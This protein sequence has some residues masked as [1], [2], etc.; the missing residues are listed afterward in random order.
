[1]THLPF[2]NKLLNQR[3]IIRKQPDEGFRFVIPGSISA[4]EKLRQGWIIL[5]ISVSVVR[6]TG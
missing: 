6:L 2:L 3:G 1:M 4:C 5:V